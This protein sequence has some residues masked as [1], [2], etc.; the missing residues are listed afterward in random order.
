[1]ATGTISGIFVVDIDG[2][3][4]EAELK[5][6]EQRYDAL[7]QT[8]ESITARGR[9]V[10]F[11]MPLQ[12]L[13]N[14]AGK[15]APGIDVRADG[16]YVLA[17]PSMHP[18]GRAYCWSVDSGNTFA[19]A[20]DWLLARISDT[21]SDGTVA[22]T[23]ASEWRDLAKGVAEGARDCSAA[24]LAGHL[25]HRRVDPFVTLELLRGWNALRAAAAGRGHRTNC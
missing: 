23:P 13:R 20:P 9:H 24:R 5:K 4:A 11:R 8:V 17:P 1:V 12:R 6:L 10:F 16:G 14:S 19:P 21:H 25:L 2:F 3:D 7:P 22:A 18:S 15:I